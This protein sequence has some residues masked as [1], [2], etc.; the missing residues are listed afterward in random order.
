MLEF[1]FINGIFNNPEIIEKTN[2]TSEMFDNLATRNTFNKLKFDYTKYNKTDFINRDYFI[3][4][5]DKKSEDWYEGDLEKYTNLFF[6]SISE[7][8]TFDWQYV[9]NLLIK[10]YK[11][12]KIIN[13][14]TKAI[15]KIEMNEDISNVFTNLESEIK[16]VGEGRATEVINAP[17]F[18]ELYDTITEEINRAN[19]SGKPS[20]YT[21]ELF[22]AIKSTTRMKNGWLWTLVSSTGG[23]KTV[24]MCLLTVL[25]AK[26][27]K[28]RC[29]FITD[30]NSKEVILSYMHCGY[31]GL[32][33]YDI[34]DRK[35]NLSSYIKNLSPEKKKEYDEIFNLIDV[36]E[37]PCIPMNEVRKI[38][39]TAK[40]N[41]H[42][43][44]WVNVN[45][46]TGKQIGRA[47]V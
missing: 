43:Y 33:Y 25:F 3:D 28:E 1:R 4:I 18:M 45:I 20:H 41:E 21:L 42:P 35:I 9:E 19:E 47:H 12:R 40:N 31:F 38:I 17:N 34:E 15:E 44:T 27:Y 32:K 6:N 37:M 7:N 11:S 23:G 26:A 24:I 13:S 16:N 10:D 22:E 46:V 5:F 30:E 29:L 36:I 14:L 8:D 39:K 2:L